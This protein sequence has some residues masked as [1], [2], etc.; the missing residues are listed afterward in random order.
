M[1]KQK[2][3]QYGLLCKMERAKT[4]LARTYMAL[5]PFDTHSDNQINPEN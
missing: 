3:K 2:L 1:M 5:G 4:R